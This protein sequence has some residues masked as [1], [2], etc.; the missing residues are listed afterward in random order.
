MSDAM[1]GGAFSRFEVA[2]P[3]VLH[4]GD[5]AFCYIAATRIAV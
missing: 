4:G 5:G 3:P 1:R 2:S